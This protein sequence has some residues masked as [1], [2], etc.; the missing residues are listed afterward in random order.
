M[1]RVLGT[2]LALVLT[3]SIAP[4]LI[5]PAVAADSGPLAGKVVVIDPG[6]QRGNS[7]PKYRAQVNA[8][9]F[10]GSIRKACNT[11]G[12]ATNAGYPESTFTWKVAKQLERMLKAE[13]ATVVLTRNGDDYNAY[14]PCIWN[15]AKV[16]NEAKADAF[17]SIHADG[18]AAKEHGFH[19]I[20]PVRI[21]GWTDDMAAS[22]RAL[23]KAMIA[24]MSA[25]GAT[26]STYIDGGLSIRSDQST[27]NFS[28]VPSVIVEVG[29]MR[30][31]K[32]AKL[33][34]SK[35]GQQQVATW[36]QAGLTRYL[37]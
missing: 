30:N 9:K 18:A 37:R 3:L 36:L 17:V 32:E 13:G 15:R 2:A 1:R 24:G 4:V 35:Q 23:A 7:N 10:N 22:S 27:L 5:A 28:D 11:T 20:A 8:K 31:A 19:V 29:N 12:T 25:A 33:F 14:G 34:S 16:A 6:H 21:K 26:K